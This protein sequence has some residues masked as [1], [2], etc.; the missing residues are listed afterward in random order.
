M[1]HGCVMA[2]CMS[3]ERGL[4]R[5]R[6]EEG[7]LREELG[8]VGNR[9]SV[10]GPRQVCLFDA[11]TYEALRSEGMKVGPGSFG[12][13]LTLTGIPFADLRSGDRLKIGGEAV[14]EITMVRKPCSNLTQIDPRLPD[15]VAGRSG[16]MAKVVTGGY[17]RPGDPVV[18][19][20]RGE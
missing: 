12:E 6:V 20:G 17:V 8:F 14:I 5:P 19:V 2:V 7:I 3:A 13:N 16:W 11:E 1:S 9:H 15:A 4:P 10:G 18:V